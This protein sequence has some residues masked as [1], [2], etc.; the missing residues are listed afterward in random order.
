MSEAYA[1]RKAIAEELIADSRIYDIIGDR[2]FFSLK[3]VEEELP[4]IVFSLVGGPDSRTV[5]DNLI[6]ANPVYFIKAISPEDET[7]SILSKLISEIIPAIDR[8]ITFDSHTYHIFGVRREN[9]NQIIESMHGIS[10]YHNGAQFRF[11]VDPVT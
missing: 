1:A 8:T 6:F 2:V 7:A 9:E 11:E 3:P 4:A 5:D 10:Y